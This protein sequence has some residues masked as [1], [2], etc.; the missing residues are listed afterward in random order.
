MKNKKLFLTIYVLFVIVLAVSIIVLSFLGKKERVGYLSDLKL[1]IDRTLEI[2]GLDINEVKQLFNINNKLGDNDITNYVFTNTSITNYNYNFR[3]KYYDKIFRNSD[4]YGVYL[5]TNKVIKDNN[6]IKNINISGGSP[7]GNLVSTKVIDFEKIDNINYILKLKINIIYKFIIFNVFILL[8]YLFVK[9]YYSYDNKIS[10][11]D[12]IKINNIDYLFLLV[13]F[14]S[15]LLLF[16][17][18]LYVF[19]PGYFKS[20]DNI[21][22]IM[23]GYYHNYWNGHPVFNQVTLSLLNSV[24]GYS[25]SYFFIINLICWYLGLFLIITSLYLKY[26][27]KLFYFLIFVSFIGNIWFANNYQI[28]DITAVNYFW[29]STSI[30]LFYIFVPLQKKFIILIIGI[31]VLILSMISRHNMIV[32]IYPLF[33]LITFIILNKKNITDIKSYILL[34]FN[35]MF[36]FSILLILIF[37]YQPTLWMKGSSLYSGFTQHL[38]YLPISACASISNDENLIPKEWYKEGTN[39]NDIK[40]FYFK[41]SINADAFGWGPTSKIFVNGLSD[42]EVQKVF[43]KSISKHPISWIKHVINFG[44]NIFLLKNEFKIDYNQYF[45]F[46]SDRLEKSKIPNYNRK[47]SNFNKILFQFF[48][49]YLIDIDLYIFLFFDL[50]IFFILLYL[51]FIDINYINNY[52]F[53]FSISICISSIVTIMIVTMFTPIVILRYIYPIVPISLIVFILFIAFICEEGGIKN[54]FNNIINRKKKLKYYK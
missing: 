39:F 40:K 36:I 5:D 22:I 13:T 2:N 35:L 17:L 51:V 44:K 52:I 18:Q 43:I 26:K 49:K 54:I 33:I 50:L 16:S 47:I 12:K 8:L 21:D 30:I 38:Y 4:I 41:N 45:N 37:K 20:W 1:N 42:R 7:F 23:F 29:L 48:Y 46:Y 14:I 10:L 15:I 28:K 25:P 34:F 19:F 6:F 9:K 32:T 3:I 24:F 31:F 53:V 27:S 11:L